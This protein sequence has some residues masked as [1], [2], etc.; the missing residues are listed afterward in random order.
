MGGRHKAGHDVQKGDLAFMAFADDT[1]G[2]GALSPT[3]S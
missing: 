3:H 2:N 1:R